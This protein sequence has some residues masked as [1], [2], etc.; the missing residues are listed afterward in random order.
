MNMKGKI[1]EKGFTVSLHD[2]MGQVERSSAA[3]DVLTEGLPDELRI[4]DE[5]GQQSAQP[6]RI[7]GSV[8]PRQSAKSLVRCLTVDG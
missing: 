1:N 2:A 6:Q 3:E 8:T 7:N 4:G 5:D